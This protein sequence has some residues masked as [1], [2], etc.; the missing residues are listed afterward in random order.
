MTTTFY[1]ISILIMVIS[2]GVQ[3]RFRSR[4]RRFSQNGLANGL[5]GAEIA[6]KML[7]DHGIYDV[8]VI[9]TAGELTDHYDPTKK[10]VN[11]SDDVFFGRSTLAAAVAAH[12]CGHAVQHAKAYSWLEFRST[13]VGP[14][15][16]ASRYM[17]WVILGG[18]VL[19]AMGIGTMLLKVGVV[20][21]ALTTV[22]SFVTLPVEF[23]ASKR[24]L[25]WLNDKNMVSTSEGNEAREALNWAATTYVMA[26]LSSLATLLYYASLLMGDD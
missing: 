15:S 13:M 23:D 14:V 7:H 8:Q 17:T 11:L 16:V 25:A 3:F 18:F 6:T 10:T 2:I 5:S 1:F 4:A 22:F 9:H 26:A 19:A 12:E 21:F 20:L 24:A